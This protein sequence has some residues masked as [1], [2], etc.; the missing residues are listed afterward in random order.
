MLRRLGGPTGSRAPETA[1]TGLKAALAACRRVLASV[2]VISVVINIL[3][4]TG[5]F[6]MLEV[7]DRVIPSRSMPTL[8]AIGLLAAALYAC[9]GV[10]D[11][12]RGRIFVRVGNY[13]DSALNRDV[14]YAIEHLSLTQQRA[15]PMQPGRDL[16]QIRA[17]MS[18]GGPVAFFDLPWL[19]FYILLC[20]LFHTWIG[21]AAIFGS[22]LLIVI[23]FLTERGT[24][25]PGKEA[26]RHAM[27]RAAMAEAAHRNAEV[28][29]ALGMGRRLAERWRG[30]NNDYIQETGRASDVALGFGALS[31][32]L[33]MAIQSGVLALGAYLVIVGQATGGVMIASSILVARALAPVELA[34][35]NWKGFVAAR[36]AWHR[37][38]QVLDEMPKR[39]PM[40]LP[41]PARRVDVR[42]LHLVV[43]GTSRVIVSDVGFH[44]NAG[45]AMGIIGSS[46]SG[47][48]S[49]ARGLVGVWPAARGEVRFDGASITNWSPERLGRH[50]GYLPQ[51]V[52]LFA[53][54]VA[55]NIAR[56]AP[57][58]ASEDVIEAARA[59]GVHEMILRLPEGY[60][61]QIGEQGSALSAGQRQRVALARAL[62]GRPFLVVLD[63]PNSNLDSE[64]DAALTAAVLSVRKRGGI[65]VVIA[66]RPSAIKGCDWLL[67]MRDGRCLMFDLAEKVLEA[68]AKPAASAAIAEPA[69]QPALSSQGGA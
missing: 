47:K 13:L 23:T 61:S 54:T 4:L 20:F 14:F 52:E 2:A 62:F 10:L 55:E 5:S 38:S 65:V 45:S 44:L 56:F 22:I 30:I 26:V 28:V 66:H 19:P 6:F 34:I 12:I 7:Y 15:D 67:M 1:E 57:D 68:F 33:R 69:A 39:E 40:E 42:N 63:E 48:S 8:A 17:F 53:G 27:K 32:V 60:D 49:L 59:A 35:G 50:I 9:Q 36:Q 64:G 41:A 51:N 46:A 37:L 21:L 24:S 25:A 3:Y 31:K 58:F 11:F 29:R 18:N 16:D 43:P